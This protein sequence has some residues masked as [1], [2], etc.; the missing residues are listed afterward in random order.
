MPWPAARTLGGGGLVN[1][2]PAACEAFT[3]LTRTWNLPT[4]LTLMRLGAFPGSD[5]RFLGMLGTLE[6]NLAMH[7]AD[8]VICIG[9]RFDDRVTGRLADFFP[10]ARK[11][12]VDIHPENIG[13]VVPV[14]VGLAV[15][16][17]QVLLAP[18]A[19]LAALARAPAGALDD[20]WARIDQWRAR[21]CLAFTP[22]TDS[23][24]PTC[25]AQRDRLHRRRPAS[26][27]G[28]AVPA[29]R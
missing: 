22:A 3:A 28:G 21:D 14:D 4:T 20:W 25:E 7:R 5:P 11:I 1:S 12:H 17:E 16:C 19:Q 6:A 26:D 9:G 27:V 29:L 10:G 23:I 24:R 18:D 13:K 8:H 2:G 15:D